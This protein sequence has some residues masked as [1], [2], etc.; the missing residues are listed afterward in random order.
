M[1]VVWIN[2]WHKQIFMIWYVANYEG[3]FY[4]FEDELI[5]LGYTEEYLFKIRNSLSI[6]GYRDAT[7]YAKAVENFK[8][9][10]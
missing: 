9:L 7:I 5:K 3:V 1:D 4:V 8:F 2:D 6:S 10:L